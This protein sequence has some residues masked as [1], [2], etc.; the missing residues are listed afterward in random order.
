V[1]K[2][3]D[4]LGQLTGVARAGRQ[5]TC[6]YDEPGQIHQITYPGSHVVTESYDTYRRWTG[7]GTGQGAAPPTGTTLTVTS[8]L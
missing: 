8:C 5:V 7:V 3:W 1:V 2:H 4:S 6:A